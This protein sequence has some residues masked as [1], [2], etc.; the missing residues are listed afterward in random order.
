MRL[1]E[2]PL[3]EDRRQFILCSFLYTEWA[4]SVYFCTHRVFIQVYI[5]VYNLFIYIFGTKSFCFFLCTTIQKCIFF[6][7]LFFCTHG[8]SLL[9]HSAYYQ[10]SHFSV[11]TMHCI[12]SPF[13][14]P[15]EVFSLFAFLNT[16]EFVKIF[17]PTY[18]FSIFLSTIP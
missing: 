15:Q 12:S 17:C 5:F 3:R 10:L 6:D 11:S 13:R 9:A 16:S 4:K 2:K 14:L 8:Q 7:K 1:S 18:I